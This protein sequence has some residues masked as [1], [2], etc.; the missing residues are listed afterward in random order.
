[1]SD[2]WVFV[3]WAVVWAAAFAIGYIVAGWWWDR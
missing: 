3:V 1:M 2:A